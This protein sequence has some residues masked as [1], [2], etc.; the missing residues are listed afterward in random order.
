MLAPTIERAQIPY[1]R[2]THKLVGAT[3][4][5]PFEKTLPFEADNP[6]PPSAELPL[7]RGAFRYLLFTGYMIVVFAIQNS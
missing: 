2:I 4:G 5:R 1:N 7:H 6:S 3:I